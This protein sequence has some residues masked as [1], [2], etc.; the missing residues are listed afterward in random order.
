[1]KITLKEYQE[2]AEEIR[3]WAD[4]LYDGVRGYGWELFVGE[5]LKQLQENYDIEEGTP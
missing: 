4:E 3:E 1:M 5:Q 2:M